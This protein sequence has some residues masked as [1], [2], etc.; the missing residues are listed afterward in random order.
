MSIQPFIIHPPADLVQKNPH[1][2][3]LARQLSLQ[4]VH[5]PLVP[6]NNLKQMGQA[7]WQA[8]KI[9]K[10]FAQAKQH[11]GIQ[12]LPL[13][14][15][16]ADPA[17]FILPWECLYHPDD[18]FLGKHPNY[19][20]SRRWL[21][22]S[23]ESE[24]APGF[25]NGE[26]NKKLSLFKWLWSF[27]SRQSSIPE[28]D[29]DSL[30]PQEEGPDMRAHLP[31][32][33]LRV[34]LFTSQPDDL[35]PETMRLDIETEQ[36]HV[37][38]ALDPFILQGLVQIETPDDGRFS[39]FKALLR[40]KTFHLVFLSGHGQFNAD[41]FSEHP[42]QAGFLFEGED[43]RGELVMAPAMAQA[44][45][46]TEVQ[47]VVLSAC[48]SGKAA[49]EDLNAGLMTG[50]VA[51]G[52]PHVVGMRESIYDRAGI[53]FAHTFGK[54]VAQQK[55]LDVAIQTSRESITQPLATAGPW[56]DASR[57]GWAEASLSQWCLPMLVSHEPLQPLID[58]EF[59]PEPPRA[60]TLLVDSL[61]H[62]VTLPEVFIGRRKELREL[63][64]A[65]AT[66]Q[67][68]SLLITGPGGQG[69]T[70]LAGKLARKLE[71]Q[72]FLIQA[73]SA[74]PSESSW[75]NFLFQL[76]S[77]LP[78][79]LLEQVER[80]W[81]LC[82]NEAQRA[83]LLLSALVQHSGG[84]LLLLFDNL[85]SVQDS[86]SGALTDATLETW[87]NAAQ[88][89]NKLLILL[90]SRWDLPTEAVPSP[91]GS[92]RNSKWFH[93]HILARP[94]YGDFLRYLQELHLELLWETKRELYKALGG[95]FK[96]LQLFNSAQQLGIGQAAFLER[97]QTAQAGLQVYMA[98]EQVVS[99]LQAEEKTLLS[100]LPVYTTPVTD[101]GIKE[102]SRDL[103]EPVRLLQRLVALSLVDVE[104]APDFN[105]QRVYQISPL[106]AE[107]L[108]KQGIAPPSLAL[109]KIAAEHQQM[110]FQRLTTLS[111]A[112]TVHEA[113]QL[114]ELPEEANRFALK[115]IVP[116]FERIGMYRTLLDKWL[117]TLRES[118][119]KEILA[120]ALNWSGTTY[121][122][123]GDYDQALDY[124]QQSLSIKREI[125]DKAGEGS[126]L[127]NISQIYDA[128]GDYD[129]ALDYLQQSLQIRREIGDKK[130]E[131]TTLNNLSQ[132]FQAQGDYDQALDYLQQSLKIRREIGDKAG[133]GTTLNNLSQIYDAQGD[134]D[135]ALDYLQQS[136]KIQQEI[137]DKAGEGTTL[138]NLSQ[139]YDAK[140]DYEQALDYL[141]Q[142]LKIT[143]EIGD[144]AGEGITLSN[145][146]LIFKAQG[147]YDQALDYLQ[148]S[149][150]I[151]QEIGDKSGEG[152]TLGNIANIYYAKG[153][154]DNA[155]DYIQQS[156][157]TFQEIGD[158][159][160]EGTTLNNLSQIYHAKGD[161]DQALDYLQQSLKIQQEIG[162]AAGL[163][164]TLNNM[165][166]I[167]WTKGDKK[168]AYA[169][170]VTAYE[171]A[172][173]IGYHQ[174]L[175]ALERKA[176]ELGGEGLAFWAQKSFEQDLT[177]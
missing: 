152:T 92:F 2:M 85:E 72:G 149:L 121:H 174:A 49:S 5:Q 96:G 4:Y 13:I 32:G 177:D 147:D 26:E 29:K 78:N 176:K 155:L 135:Q 125:G 45:I 112:I 56:R 84:R 21:A 12:I 167:Y 51:A 79:P 131:G 156:L 59:T 122:A 144:K 19:A 1:L 151:Q 158:R 166:H 43:G 54:T 94:S 128:R 82:E 8:L 110:I 93:H 146:S 169:H 134:Y 109:R 83:E 119:D 100:R 117:P 48:Q 60:Q 172:S 161:Y 157:K 129:Q 40:N 133:E 101:I 120:R 139:I 163:C 74:R 136:L 30:L 91:T 98:V 173:K 168:Q 80:R 137:G 145:L 141:Q 97:L 3:S 37:L 23:S 113:L 64:Q 16:T 124:L 118:E 171:I 63:G 18:G 162:D 36:A 9:D 142:S 123:I 34:L 102:I 77:N 175:V 7:L 67:I 52:L 170:W 86:A 15:E 130:G 50:L 70:S 65:L 17:I 108:K 28:N 143:R 47:C 150:K 25:D 148:Q 44:F 66:G 103:P 39:T 58:W 31:K 6:E 127:N 68:R 116:T 132:I 42:N 140:G 107:W 159:A 105:N 27:V 164:A 62:N 53:I 89:L 10:A 111:Q 126:T 57:E 160:K 73:Y 46:G 104:T 61:A 76:K 75:E 138:N 41:A 71:S 69:K 106:L 81:G 115:T 88:R 22:A 165:G 87:L 99:Y 153:S 55:R 38:E 14:I 11:A 35:A 114:A 95:N 90:T 20:L 33:P 24:G 154:Y